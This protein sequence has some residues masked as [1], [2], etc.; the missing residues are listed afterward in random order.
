[1]WA[2][3]ETIYG[4]FGYGLAAFAGEISLRREYNAFAEPLTAE[5]SVR[6][7][8]HDEALRVFPR[9]WDAVRR[10]TPGMT[11]RSRAWWETRTL[12]DAPDNRAGG[13]PK[14]L[15]LLEYDGRPQGYAIYRHK[16]K[17]EHGV[18]EAELSVIEA[19]A[20]D[21]R[22][23]AELWRFLLDIDWYAYLQAWLLPPDHP[24]FFLLATPR[25]MQYRM[26]DGIWVR[27]VDVG[28]ALSRRSY[29]ADQAVV[30]EVRDDFCPWNEGRWRIADGAAKRTR[31]APQL[32]CDVSA[33]GSAYLG[34][35]R[36]SQLVLGG[37]AE[38]LRRGA[39][40]RADALFR[41]ERAPWCPEI[42]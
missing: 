41:T 13:G 16:P 40:G 37:R 24:L 5:G 4:R 19:I 2:S 23:T 32:R 3:E 36:F 1:L 33:L 29:A 10:R 31:A 35:V 26:G 18:S 39:A 25:R 22:P 9:V 20:L 7:V 21:G 30:I 17:W 27:L 42:F 15:A 34:G 11:S 12:R 28:E 38:E 14:R 6:I 8:E